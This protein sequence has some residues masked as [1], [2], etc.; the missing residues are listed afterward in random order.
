MTCYII[1]EITRNKANLDLSEISIEVF[2]QSS[3]QKVIQRNQADSF[4][5]FN[6]IAAFNLPQSE[7]ISATNGLVDNE[8]EESLDNLKLS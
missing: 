2:P 4:H 8:V 6:G 5:K 7:N 1:K 3:C